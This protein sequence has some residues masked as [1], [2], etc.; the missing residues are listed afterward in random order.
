MNRKKFITGLG[1]GGIICLIILVVVMGVRKRAEAGRVEAAEYALQAKPRFVKLEKVV[2]AEGLQSHGYPG[3]VRAS[4]EAELSFRVGGPLIAVNVEL[5]RPV[6]KGDLLMQIDPRDFEDQIASLEAQLGGAKAVYKNARLDFARA[7]N[8]F[9]EA[10]IPPADF[11]RSTGALDSASAQVQTLE[12]QLQVARHRLEDTA[13]R[14]PFDG[15]VTAKLAENH[16][17]VGAGQVVL[18]YHNIQWLEVDVN[19]PEKDMA[20]RSLVPGSPAQIRFS[21]M[22]DKLYDV[23]L[24]EW[25][26]Q[27]DRLTRTY[28]VTFRFES[29]E[30]LKVLPGMSAD[31]L[32]REDAA[33]VAQLWIPH[34]ALAAT[35]EGVP[36]VWVYDEESGEASPREVKTGRMDGASRIT[37]VEGL[38]EGEQVVVTGSRL[39]QAG[40]KLR[41]V[42]L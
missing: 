26:S 38:T 3:K 29:P 35:A 32:W 7:K 13:L 20:R 33:E 41:V 31:I 36:F 37:I 16:E 8:L 17:M 21:T 30:D 18:A 34:S 25:R 5:G 11:D 39:I 23:K 6:K 42:P 4:E 1:G 2:A 12:A 24:K 19:I 22:P 28:V 9:E 14:A 27:A 40:E 15:Q 10:V